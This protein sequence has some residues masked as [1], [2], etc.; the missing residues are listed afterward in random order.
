V[1]G[2]DELRETDPRKVGPFTLVGRLGGGSTGTVYLGRTATG[3]RAAVKV[4]HEHLAR[5]PQ[6]RARFAREVDVYRRVRGLYVA[7]LID[8]DADGESLWLATRYIEASLRQQV[9]EHGPLARGDVLSLGAG[10]AETVGSVHAAG[11]VHR[12]LEPS[13]VVLADD[14]PHVVGLDLARAADVSALTGTGVL[15]GTFEYLSPEQARGEMATAASDVFALGGILHFAATGRPPFGTGH[16]AAVIQRI[17]DCRADLTGIG[18]DRLRRLTAACLVGEPAARPTLAEVIAECAGGSPTGAPG[19]ASVSLKPGFPGAQPPGEPGRTEILRSGDWSRP[20][21]GDRYGRL[22]AVVAG[23]A[24]VAVGGLSLGPAARW[25]GAAGSGPAPYL[26]RVPD[27]PTLAFAPAW[28][29]ATGETDGSVR[30]WTTATGACAHPGDH[31]RRSIGRLLPDG[32][33]L[34]SAG[35]DGDVRVWDPVTGR[36][37][38]S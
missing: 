14:G 23:A 13:G 25:C 7:T 10:V 33:T 2:V 37:A 9:V 19:R 6:F 24:V 17:R 38:G 16:P 22:G 31:F 36:L 20:C 1:F 26:D 35:G 12:G 27:R 5:V 18:D 3:R 15:V 4:V 21:F 8:A 11:L 28:T 29:F 32:V 34:V 30:I